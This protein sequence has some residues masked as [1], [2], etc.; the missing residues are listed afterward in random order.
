MVPRAVCAAIVVALAA[1]PALRAQAPVAPVTVHG[2][3][4]DSLHGVPLSNAFIVIGG[5]SRSATSDATGRF[6]FE[7]VTPGTYRFIM[8]HDVLDSIGMSGAMTRATITDGR[9]IVR[10]SVPSFAALWNAACRRPAPPVDSGLIFGTVHVPPGMRSPAGAAVTATWSD[11]GFDKKTGVSEQRWRLAA[12]ADST[13]NYTLCGVPTTTMLSI[14]ASMDSAATGSIDVMPLDKARIRR[15]DLLFGLPVADVLAAKRG[16][17]F[18]GQVLTDS[19]HQGIA[20]AAVELPELGIRGL[21]NDKGEFRLGD[22]LP[23]SHQV[24]VRRIG[25]MLFDTRLEFVENQTLEHTVYLNRITLLDSVNVKAKTAPRDPM[26]EAF[27]EHKARGFGS[28]FTRAELEKREGQ[29]LGAIMAQT[30]GLEIVYGHNGQAWVLGKHPPGTPCAVPSLAQRV[31]GNPGFERARMCFRQDGWYLPDKYE[32]DRGMK[33]ACYATVFQDHMAMN[34]SADPFDLNS[35]RA[36]Q[37]EAIEW[38]SGLSQTPLEYTV[39]RAACGVLV[40]HTRRA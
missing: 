15:R 21:T 22:I 5:T 7:N 34:Q 9:A 8:Q 4:F 10:I 25:Y 36:D 23:G 33:V 17:V 38:Y 27:A 39:R 6:V 13:G 29:T 35:V 19:T 26:M 16:A 3:A 14:R 32:E 12:A 40:I 11:I 30:S 20:N 24:R 37:I 18:A 28:F 31:S 1:S 2:I